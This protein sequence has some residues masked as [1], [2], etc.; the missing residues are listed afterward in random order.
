MLGA[1]PPRLA[2]RED[3]SGFASASNGAGAPGPTRRRS[4][5]ELLRYDRASTMRTVRLGR[6]LALPALLLS[7]GCANFVMTGTPTETLDAV[8]EA[9][10][11]VGAT[12][13]STTPR[14]DLKPEELE[15]TFLWHPSAE[16]QHAGVRTI[17]V[18]IVPWGDDTSR[19]RTITFDT[20]RWVGAPPMWGGTAKEAQLAVNTA[21]NEVLAE[22][23]R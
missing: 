19:Q 16:N 15:A 8:R 6:L 12:E 23:T 17:F 11:R 3:G 4:T 1:T 7:P 21:M 18:R 20:W 13:E 22:R 5:G 10:T 9:M 2:E 14:P